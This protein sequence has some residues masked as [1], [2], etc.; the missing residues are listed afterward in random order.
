M[1]CSKQHYAELMT[2]LDPYSTG[3]L[4][5]SDLFI[6]HM[7]NHLDSSGLTLKLN[8]LNVPEQ[9]IDELAH[10]ALLQTR[11]CKIIHVNLICRM[12]GYLSSD[13]CLIVIFIQI[14]M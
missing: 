8:Q 5:A 7:Q 11:Y 9:M 4:M 12:L 1:L 13:L 14:V 3:C 2:W 6:D 10:D